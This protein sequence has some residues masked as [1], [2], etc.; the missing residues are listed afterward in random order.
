MENDILQ[1][2]DPRLRQP[3]TAVTDFGEPFLE[4]DAE[5]LYAALTRFRGTQGFGRAI[6]APQLGIRRRMIALQLPNWPK[7]I[8]NPQITHRAEQTFTLWDDCMCFPNLRVRLRRHRSVWVRF[9]SL[10]GKAHQREDCDLATSEL[11]QHEI[12]HLDGVLA[13][14]RA[15]D[16]NALVSREAFAQHRDYFLARV[17]YKGA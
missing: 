2:G 17:D 6:A 5:R 15:L 14:D 7:I 10:D 4:R 16:K 12:D 3:A 1:L 8:V 13:V 11:L 9:F